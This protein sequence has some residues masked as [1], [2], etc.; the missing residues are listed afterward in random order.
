MK[1]IGFIVFFSLNFTQLNFHKKT[2]QFTTLDSIEVALGC[3]HRPLTTTAGPS[4]ATI[5]MLR[6]YDVPIV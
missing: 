4:G 5:T 2:C 3:C 1:N 6:Y